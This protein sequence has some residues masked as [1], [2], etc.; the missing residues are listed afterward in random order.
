MT[1]DKIEMRNEEKRTNEEEW[2][3]GKNGKGREMRKGKE[4]RL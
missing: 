1:N 2:E 3:R 4:M